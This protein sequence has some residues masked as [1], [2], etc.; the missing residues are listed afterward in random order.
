MFDVAD[1]FDD[2]EQPAITKTA[3]T[4]TATIQRVP[5]RASYDAR[6]SGREQVP[7]TPDPPKPGPR[8][9]VP[10]ITRSRHQNHATRNLLSEPQ[11]QIGPQIL[12]V[13]PYPDD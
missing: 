10:T 1:D 9:A 4:T 13:E 12:G 6:H 7:T 2:D 8:A 11:P 5:I 3:T